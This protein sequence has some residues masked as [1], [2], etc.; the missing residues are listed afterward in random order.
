MTESSRSRWERESAAQALERHVGGRRDIVIGVEC[1]TMRDLISLLRSESERS[2][3]SAYLFNGHAFT[4]NLLTSD[5]RARAVPLYALPS[6]TAQRNAVLEEAAQHLDVVYPSNGA[7]A[8]YVRSLKRG[9][10]E[11]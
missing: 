9:N 8:L 1:P 2:E 6:A 7:P 11:A 10:D 5:Q 4:P 3:P